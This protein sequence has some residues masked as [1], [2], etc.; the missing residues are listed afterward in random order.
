MHKLFIA[1][2]IMG[3]E[4]AR[5]L[6]RSLSCFRIDG[7][8]KVYDAHIINWGRSDLHING[9]RNR[10]INSP[11][12]V[13]L[14]ANKIETFKT[15]TRDGVACVDWT[16]DKEQ[17]RQWLD[18]GHIVYARTNVN[19]SSGDGIVIVGQDDL[20]FPSARLYTKGFNKTH[21]YRVHVAFG[22]VIDYSKKRKRNDIAVNPYI[23][24]FDS[25]WVFCRDGVAL[26]ESVSDTCIAA[27]DSLGLDF[28][29]LDVLYKERDNQV[30]VLEVNTAPG[31]EGTTLTKYTEAFKI[32][33]PLTINRRQYGQDRFSLRR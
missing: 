13:G 27:I 18:D 22:S 29:A 30:K 4:S 1:P 24:N 14:A 25:G 5:D 17:A 19:G 3:S 26:P 10:I 15:L 7:S 16:L 23:K 6:A 33:C 2:Y 9:S 11:Q 31:I 12:A 21:E 8:K 20:H 32:H 28:G